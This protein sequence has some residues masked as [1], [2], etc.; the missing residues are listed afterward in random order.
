MEVGDATSHGETNRQN[1]LRLLEDL[2]SDQRTKIVAAA[3]VLDQGLVLFEERLDKNWSLTDCTSFA[4]MS[5][6]GI[7]DA[8]TGDHHFE[9]AGFNALLK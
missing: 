8:L 2:R 9:Q 6:L 3:A 5:E 7:R 4:T 1:F